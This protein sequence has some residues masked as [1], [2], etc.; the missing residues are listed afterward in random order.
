MVQNN[1]ADRL[2]NWHNAVQVRKTKILTTSKRNSLNDVISCNV[3]DYDYNYTADFG[4]V[5]DYDY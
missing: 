3:I 4:L 5:I 2:V 1:T